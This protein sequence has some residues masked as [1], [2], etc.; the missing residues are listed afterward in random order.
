MT[1]ADRIETAS[2]PSYALDCEVGQ[3]VAKAMGTPYI[4]PPRAYTASIDAALAL[5]PVG[6]GFSVHMPSVPDPDNRPSARVWGSL[7][8]AFSASAA[9]PALAI[10]AAALK[11]RL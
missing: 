8:G 9:T 7:R 2:G 3:Y 4:V 6:C 11:A 10:C 1:L 5:V